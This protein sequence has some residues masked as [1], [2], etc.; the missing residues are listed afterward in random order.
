MPL[1]PPQSESFL[2]LHDDGSTRS[3]RHWPVTTN[4]PY[5][6]P[7]QQH[8]TQSP[9]NWP[10]LTQVAWCGKTWLMDL[11]SG[12]CGSFP[13]RNN[14]PWPRHDL[15]TGDDLMDRHIKALDRARD[16][17]RAK[18][19]PVGVAVEMRSTRVLGP[20]HVQIPKVRG[21]AVS[22]PVGERL[23]VTWRQLACFSCTCIASLKSYP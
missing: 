14:L 10:T 7:L 9:P 23:C 21:R 20:A 19:Q 17:T 2:I 13:Q 3:S 12:G 1:S 22:P 8:F 6:G 5:P 4:V 16:K 15:G 18:E 11:Q